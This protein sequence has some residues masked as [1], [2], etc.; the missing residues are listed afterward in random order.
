MAGALPSSYD[1]STLLTRRDGTAGVTFEFSDAEQAEVWHDT[2]T[3][4]YEAAHS[5]KGGV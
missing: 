4:R 3:A 5:T 1:G 2:I